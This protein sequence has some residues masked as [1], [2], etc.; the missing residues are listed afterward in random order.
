MKTIAIASDLDL[1]Y[2]GPSID[3]GACPALF[4]FC[5]SGP[6][7]LTEHPYNQ[8]VKFLSDQPIRVFSLTLPAHEQGYPPD[9]ALTSWVEEMKR[10]RDPLE[11]FLHQCETALDYL[12]QHKLILSDKVSA[13]GLSRGA[14]LAALFCARNEKIHTLLGFAPLTNLQST[15][16]FQPIHHLPIVQKYNISLYARELS[17]KS[18][19]F[20]IGNHDQRVGTRVCFECVEQLVQACVEQ[21]IRSPQI[22]L[23]ISPSIGHLGHGTSTEKFQQGADWILQHV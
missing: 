22:E 1:Y 6:D 17:Q 18:I 10:G 23:I 14:L 21:N 20:Y 15:S 3:E 4:Y 5:L 12:L 2:T 8:I 16:E 19:R 9:E 7:T 11:K 13:A